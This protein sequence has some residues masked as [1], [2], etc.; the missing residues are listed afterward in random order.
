MARRR[1]DAAVNVEGLPELQRALKKI[2]GM[3]RELSK[4][5]KKVADVVASD[6]RGAAASLG[7]TAAHVAPSLKATA[8]ATYSAVTLGGSGY[9]MAPGAEFGSDRFRQFKPWRGGGTD[10][11]YFL[12]PTI[13]RNQ[14]RIVTEY[15]KGM[16]DLLRRA[17]L[18]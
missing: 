13:R 4:T 9:E 6:A 8:R 10:A 7:S 12:W 2:E 16:D 11:G 14:D 5:N 17:D 15:E 18:V 3:E 1:A